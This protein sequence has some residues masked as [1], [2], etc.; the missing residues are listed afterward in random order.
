MAELRAL[1]RDPVAI[2]VE[3]LGLYD[4]TWQAGFLDR[5]TQ[6][7]RRKVVLAIEMPARLEPAP[8]LGVMRQQR[9]LA[10]GRYQ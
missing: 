2:E 10:V 9:P 3:D 8:K 4:E 1:G 6:S 5:L 7:R